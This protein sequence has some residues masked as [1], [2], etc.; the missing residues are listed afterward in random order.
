M[1]FSDYYMYIWVIQFELVFMKDDV[2]KVSFISMID[3]QEDDLVVYKQV[4]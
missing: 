3:V 2:G 1:G 4:F